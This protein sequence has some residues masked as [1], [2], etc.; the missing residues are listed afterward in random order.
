MADE[1]KLTARN[2]YVAMFLFLEKCWKQTKSEEIGKLLGGMSLLQDG[3]SA[4]A[5][6]FHD[7]MQCV[8]QVTSGQ[9]SEADIRLRFI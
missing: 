7:W 1:S 3:G 4:D 2:A 6:Y 9:T 5:A 8:M